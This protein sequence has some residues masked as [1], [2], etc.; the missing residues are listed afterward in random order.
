[1]STGLTLQRR[2]KRGRIWSSRKICICAAT[3]VLS[4]CQSVARRMWKPRRI[5]MSPQTSKTAWIKKIQQQQQYY[6]VNIMCSCRGIHFLGCVRCV[7]SGGLAWLERTLRIVETGQRATKGRDRKSSSKVPPPRLWNTWWTSPGK[8]KGR[9]I[10][11]RQHLVCYHDHEMRRRKK[12]TSVS[13]LIPSVKW[14]IRSDRSN[15]FVCWNQ[16][17]NKQVGTVHLRAKKKVIC[18]DL[19]NMWA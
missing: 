9:K 8:E 7:N 6:V 11:D 13:S 5:K 17:E 2:S 14:G 18:A 3:F 16:S 19:K 4:A 12:L 15:L 10:W 1:M